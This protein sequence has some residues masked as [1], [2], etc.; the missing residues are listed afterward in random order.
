MGDTDG[1]TQRSRQDRG[2]ISDSPTGS[3]RAVRRTDRGLRGRVA[4]IARLLVGSHICEISNTTWFGSRSSREP[5]NDM[6]GRSRSLYHY[7]D[8]ELQQEVGERRQR[9]SS[10]DS[11][12]TDGS[13]RNNI[14][15]I[16]GQRICG[17]ESW[18]SQWS[19]SLGDSTRGIGN[20]CLSILRSITSPTEK[21]MVTNISEHYSTG[22]PRVRSLW[23][24]RSAAS[25]RCLQMLHPLC[26]SRS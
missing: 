15:R 12:T 4:G 24:S 6:G 26:E 21:Q 23:C 18:L 25:A 8:A 22:S 13:H 11:R 17:E 1:R 9:S 3:I 16:I 7:Q 5:G 2:R 10:S 19:R 14:S 20:W